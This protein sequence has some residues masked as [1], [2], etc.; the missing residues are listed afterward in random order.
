MDPSPDTAARIMAGA[1]GWSIGTGKHQR[2]VFFLGAN[3]SFPKTHVAGRI[4]NIEYQSI[5]KTNV[6]CRDFEFGGHG[7]GNQFACPLSRLDRRIAHHQ[8]DTA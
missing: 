1:F 7:T 8:R 2:A 5:G 4:T 6:V 3:D